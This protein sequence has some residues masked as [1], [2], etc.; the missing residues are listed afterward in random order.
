MAKSI[1]PRRRR[2]TELFVRRLKGGEHTYLIWD[3]LAR[4]LALRVQPTGARAWYCVYSRHGRPR[5]LHLGDARA[6]GLADARMLAGETMLAAAKGRDPAAERRAER[7]K[8]TFEE[9]AARY[10]EHAK[11]KNK[12]WKQAAFLTRRYLLPKWAKLQVAAITRADVKTVHEKIEAPALANQILASA[13]AIFS[14]AMEEEIVGANPCRGVKRNETK[15]RERVLADSE[16]P[17][18]WAGFDDAGLVRS[19]A[20]KVILLTGQRPGE[21]SHMRREH[22]VDGWWE[23][24]GDPV[25]TLGWPG[26]KNAHSHR[27]WLSAPVQ[28]LLAELSD[29]ATTGLVF[30]NERGNPIDGLP[31][32]MRDVC[33]AL[34]A[35]RA[36]PHDLRRTFSTTVAALEGQDAM[37]RVTNHR[38]GG[39]TSVYDRYQYA[40]ENQK[41]MEAVAARIMSLVKGT[42]A[43][44]KVVPMV[45]AGRGAGYA[46]YNASANYEQTVEKTLVE[47]AA[48]LAPRP[49]RKD[50]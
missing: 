16:I 13:S 40:V 43:D 15:S 38:V 20:L 1:K 34:D 28:E 4:H 41:V 50:V 8:G 26:T 42:P 14:W 35:P 31:G 39:I 36:T 45:A 5:W 29:D 24:P 32:A 44:A 37:N 2:L 6:I 17:K 23:L 12:S 25:P 18:F 48:V 49:P 10:L 21:V 7:S 47:R 9:L 22:I 11:K 3:E 33:K 19:A 27:V 46:R 30:A